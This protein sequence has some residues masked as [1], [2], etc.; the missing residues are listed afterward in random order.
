MGWRGLG[1]VVDGREKRE[2]EMTNPTTQSL[3]LLL[4][5]STVEPR[6]SELVQL[7]ELILLIT[8]S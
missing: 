2:K 6:C 7:G 8:D 3:L 1:V 4:G 5:G